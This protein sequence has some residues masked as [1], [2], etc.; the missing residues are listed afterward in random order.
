MNHLPTFCSPDIRLST[1]NP[2]PKTCTLCARVLI[3][4]WNFKL[5][6]WID[7]LAESPQ[8]SSC[9][10][11]IVSTYDYK[12]IINPM[13]C[14][15]GTIDIPRQQGGQMVLGYRDMLYQGPLN[16]NPKPCR[17]YPR[18]I[19][20]PTVVYW[21]NKTKMKRFRQHIAPLRLSPSRWCCGI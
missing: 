3:Y 14:W 19:V 13:K 7:F 4:R 8:I 17:P 5:A 10:C 9:L 1:Q 21:W 2:D 11:T 12:S 15:R 6:F 16:P 20:S 18:H